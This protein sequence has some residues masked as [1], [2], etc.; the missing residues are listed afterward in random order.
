[1]AARTPLSVI[2]IVG[3]PNVGKSTLFNRYAGRRR[4]LVQDVPGVTRDR[5]VEEIAVGAR[6][7]LLVDT[8]GLDPD[9][10]E[11]LPGAVQAQARVAVAEADAILFVV[12]GKHGVLPEDE[13]IARALRRSAKPLVLVVNKIDVPGHAPRVAEFHRLGIASV[14]AVS[15]EHGTGAFEALEAAVAALP[16]QPPAEEQ[17]DEAGTLRIAIVGRPNVGKS[18]LVNRLLGSER[19]VVSNEPGT[20]RDAID[21]LVVRGEE[22]FV[23]VD[24]AGLRRPGKRGEAI[25]RGSA[26]MAVRSL[27]RAD[28]ALVVV[29]ASEGFTDADARVAALARER[30]RA[31]ALLANKWDLVERRSPAD[32][33]RVRR[34]IEDGIRFMA[35][36]PIV[37]VS[38]KT[39]LGT[40]RLFSLA[41]RLHAAAH[42]TIATGALNRWLQATVAKH[43]PGMA[44]RGQRKRP[45]KFFYATQ[46]AQAPPTFVLFCTEPAAVAPSYRRFLENRLRE[47]FDLE[48]TPVR[49]RLRARERAGGSG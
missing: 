47:S 5:L 36:T 3:R 27:E 45:V 37:V 17:A 24:T 8:A 12:D 14:F 11:G 31:A 23:L 22:R 15:A 19:V 39:G 9:A 40:A 25:E 43:E 32:R 6:R 30:G 38:A 1:M 21:T 44:Q 33:E 48:G 29:D 2:A 16:P 28:V 49:L 7:V 46:T 20:T 10:D 35:D 34:E 42:R 13:A 41:R 18:S 4:A 26:L